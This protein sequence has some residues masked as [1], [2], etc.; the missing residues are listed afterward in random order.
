VPEKP[1]ATAKAPGPQTAAPKAADLGHPLRAIMPVEQARVGAEL[2]QTID[3]RKLHAFL[4]V[5][6]D[7]STWLAD[8]IDTYGFVEGVD[9]VC[10]AFDSPKPGNQTRRG[11]DRRSKAYHLTLDMAKELA[12]IERNER[13]REARRYFIACERALR[14]AGPAPALVMDAPTR[15]ALGGIVKSVV[16]RQLEAVLERADAI[17]RRLADLD[18]RL[19]GIGTAGADTARDHAPAVADAAA[20]PGQPGGGFVPALAVVLAEAAAGGTAG[21]CRRWS[22]RACAGSVR[23]RGSRSAAPPRTAA[24]FS[25]PRRCGSG[26]RRRGRTW[27]PPARQ[28][29][30]RLLRAEPLRVPPRPRRS[31]PNHRR[32][33][34]RWAA[35]DLAAAGP[36]QRR[37]H[38]LAQTPRAGHALN[39]RLPDRAA[40]ATIGPVTPEAFIAKWRANTRS[41]AAASK[42][43]F[44]DLC[45]LLGVPSPN[46]DATGAA[47]AFEKGVKKTT[48]GGGWADV[49]RR[50]CFGWE[51]KARGGDLEAAHEQLL[52]YAGALE[53]PPLLITSDMERIVVRTNW[54]NV[55]SE[56]REF[57]L[58]DLRDPAA[59]ELLHACWTDPERWRP[60]K[61]RQALTEDAAAEFAELARRLRARPR[62]AGGGALRQPPGVLPVR[63]GRRASARRAHGRPDRHRLFLWLP[64]SVGADK[65]L[66]V[67]A[68]DDDTTLGV[69]HSRFHEAWALRLGTSLE[70]CPRY[71]PARRSRPSPSRRG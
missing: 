25:T 32:A 64:A 7:F 65:N 60:A 16:V 69:L 63:R 70:D 27:S 33:G 40:R 26:S 23:P 13:G 19:A 14:A 53:N 1:R 34:R 67:I 66:V 49:W 3:A 68:R 54:T 48:G 50:D 58:E 10:S 71:T 6:R 56:R 41:E 2:V 59:R 62:P 35:R 46:T 43:H 42:E 17:E 4:G 52:R 47:Y 28:P 8:R 37:Q 38:R 22:A 36:V 24:A 29:A 61:T 11:G 9:F 30:A 15:Q 45:A 12:M 55:V 18:R 5:G 21:R 20:G 51:Y 39:L 31:P 44:T 57:R